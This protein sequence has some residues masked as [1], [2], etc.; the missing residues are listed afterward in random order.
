[1]KWLSF[2]ELL[3]G[4]RFSTAGET[5]DVDDRDLAGRTDIDQRVK[6][7]DSLAGGRA[8]FGSGD[9]AEDTIKAIFHVGDKILGMHERSLMRMCLMEW[10]V[11]PIVLEAEG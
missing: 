9:S 11:V 4:V 1:M 2:Q 5:S 7:G 6:S 10:K 3:D 8:G